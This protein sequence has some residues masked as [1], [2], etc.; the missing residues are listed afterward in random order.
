MNWLIRGSVWLVGCICV[1]CVYLC[2]CFRWLLCKKL[3]WGLA[4]RDYIGMYSP[5]FSCCHPSRRAVR[6]RG[7]WLRYRP[8]W[9]LTVAP[10]LSGCPRRTTSSLILLMAIDLTL[11]QQN[12]NYKCFLWPNLKNWCIENSTVWSSECTECA[13]HC[14]CNDWAVTGCVLQQ[15]L[16]SYNCHW[17][18]MSLFFHKDKI[19][20][21]GLVVQR[22]E[23][24]PAVGENYMKL[25]K[26]VHICTH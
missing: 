20:L 9:V 25:K 21:E 14:W 16:H 7:R 5:S 10:C 2:V 18:L 17:V 15:Q 13:S 19:A 22:A 24:R 11:S 12:S 23:C 8:R 1:V 4:C 3:S 6:C 26:Y